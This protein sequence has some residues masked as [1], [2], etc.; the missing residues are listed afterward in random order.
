[1]KKKVS[2]LEK[3]Y[4]SNPFI[5]AGAEYKRAKKRTVVKGGKVVVDRESGTYEEMAELV[6]THEVDGEQFVKLYT[7]ELKLLFSL[8]QSA[9]KVLQ[10]VLQQVQGAVGR[11]TILLNMTIVEKYFSKGDVKPV[12]RTTFYRC[13]NEMISKGFIAPAA[14]SR[15][16]FFINPNLFFNGD[17]VRL[18]KEYHINRQGQMFDEK[19]PPNDAIEDQRQDPDEE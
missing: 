2:A 7:K 9:M 13:V 11:D 4:D 10:V 17:R 1:M 16:L 18:V 5:G 3:R 8:S 6:T 15:D 19:R 12:G 14:D